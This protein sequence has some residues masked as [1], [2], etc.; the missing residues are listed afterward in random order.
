MKFQMLKRDHC[1]ACGSSHLD[2]FRKIE[3]FPAVPLCTDQPTDQDKL[4]PLDIVVC[5]G[6]GMVQLQSLMPLEVIYEFPHSEG[7]GKVWG[8]HYVEFE[9]FIRAHRSLSSSH[10]TLE[11]GAGKGQ[12]AQIF[13]KECKLSIIEPNY[14]GPSEEIEVINDF[15]LP[16]RL[17]KLNDSFD[18]VYSSHTLEHFYDFREYFAASKQVLKKGGRL[19]TAIPN[20]ESALQAGFA[21]AFHF[22]HTALLTLP[23]LLRL[24]AEFGFEITGIS[25]YRD[26]S[27]YIAAE[28]TGKALSLDTHTGEYMKYLFDRFYHQILA[29]RQ[30][31]EN[32]LKP[33]VPHYLFGASQLSQFLFACG[34][35]AK[36]FV[37]LL[38]NASS[39]H[40]K[41]L[42]GTPLFT[43]LPDQLLK[44]GMTEAQVFING[45]PYTEEIF[46]QLQELLPETM[47]L[48]CL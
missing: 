3:H 16:E 40:G 9:Q 25:Y 34:L 21:N 46:K 10:Q 37:G 31:I 42:Y 39:K 29:T 17:E 15:Y 20:L 13:A 14:S 33:G 23:I 1:A 44:K 35:D 4:G 45:G 18:L 19:I 12:I 24:H 43:E 47:E 26:H 32:R 48:I 28:H 7:L 36:N 38:D 8:E 22:E 41:R 5:R 30:T 27:I 11:V 2:A 6:C